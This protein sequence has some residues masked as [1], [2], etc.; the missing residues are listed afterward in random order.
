MERKVGYLRA[1]GAERTKMKNCFALDDPDDE[2]G[3]WPVIGHTADAR[4][5]LIV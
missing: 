5:N 3:L 2:G 4:E 1:R